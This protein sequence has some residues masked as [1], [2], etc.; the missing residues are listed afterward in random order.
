MVTDVD[1]NDF[2]LAALATQDNTESATQLLVVIP[3]TQW[4]RLHAAL[5]TTGLGA[6]RAMEFEVIRHLCYF[7]H[8]RT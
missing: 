7:L 1:G 2:F 6:V 5:V 3:I 8:H 4:Q